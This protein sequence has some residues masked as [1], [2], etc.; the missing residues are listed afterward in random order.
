MHERFANV[1]LSLY[2]AKNKAKDS[3]YDKIAKEIDQLIVS[4]VNKLNDLEKIIQPQFKICE[5]DLE[6][7]NTT[8]FN[9]EHIKNINLA[10]SLINSYLSSC[11]QISNEIGDMLNGL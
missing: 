7:E 9:A 5:Q 8:P 11:K 3:K 2:T 1:L 4:A 6:I 10:F